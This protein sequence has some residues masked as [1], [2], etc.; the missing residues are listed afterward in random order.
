M[1]TRAS[2]TVVVAREA[3]TTLAASQKIA[4]DTKLDLLTSVG[5]G[6]GQ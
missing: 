5:P 6:S 1:R 3:M 2:Y 4:F